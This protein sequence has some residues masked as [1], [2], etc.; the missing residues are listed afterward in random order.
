MRNALPEPGNSAID[1]RHSCHSAAALRRHG[2]WRW[3]R[4]V[5]PLLLGLSLFGCRGTDTPVHTAQFA[6]FGSAAE[7]SLVG[8]PKAEAVAAAAAVKHDLILLERNFHAWEPGPLRR[9][10]ELLPTG[11]PF[12]APPSL[13]PLLRQSQALALASDHL[14]NP[15][16][17]RLQALWGF[18]TDQPECRPPP[19]PAAI[20]RLVAAAPGMDDLYLDGILLQSDNPAVQLDFNAI[21]AGYAADIGIRTLRG[22]GV[23]NGLIRIGDDVRAIGSRAGRPWR[24]PVRRTTGAAV[25]GTLPV[26]G[27]ASVF[28]A[29]DQ[30]HNFIYDGTLYHHVIDPR[31]GYPA[32][33]FRAVTVMHDGDAATAQ[34][35]AHALL[36]AGPERWHEVARR[37]GVRRV[38]LQEDATGTLLMTPALAKDFTLMDRDLS[39]VLSE[40]LTGAVAEPP[41]A[42]P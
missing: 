35:A 38:L 33:G 6:V 42:T 31:T 13:L 1:Q 11:E 40:P 21:A 19:A 14:F 17:G 36:I 28:T 23:R 18:Q 22:Y 2:R 16:S 41:S 30:R 4:L 10:N 9:V 5:I 37:L 27:D 24:V 20:A 25:L 8:M 7:V 3:P 34:A 12:A 29:S 39:V 32:S 26:L 15:A